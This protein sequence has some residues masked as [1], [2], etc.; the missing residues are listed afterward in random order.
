MQSVSFLDLGQPGS[1]VAYELAA[2]DPLVAPPAG[3]TP[4]TPDQIHLT[5]GGE[6]R[7]P[8]PIKVRV[9]VW[10]MRFK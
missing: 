1:G 6:A 2:T 5:L 7:V 4:N 9:P 8:F 3:L 10:C